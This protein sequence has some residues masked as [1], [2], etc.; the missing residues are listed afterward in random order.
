MNSPRQFEY[1]MLLLP[2]ATRREPDHDARANT[3]HTMKLRSLLFFAPLAVLAVAGCGGSSGEVPSNAIA[4]VNKCDAPITKNEFN[5][6]LNQARVN[7]TR[8]KQKFPGAGTQEYKQVQNQIVSYL[9]LRQG[10]ICEGK[11]IGQKWAEDFRKDLQKSSAV[12]YQAG[13]Q[14]PKSTTTTTTTG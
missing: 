7:Y 12:S 9:V 2:S 6:V 11:G 3:L 10:Y 4:V 14:P 8:N 5:Q 13:Y 1:S